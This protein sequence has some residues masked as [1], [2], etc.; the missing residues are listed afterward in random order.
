DQLDDDVLF[1]LGWATASEMG[2]I[3]G[4]GEVVIGHD[5]R[6]SSPGFARSFAAGVGAAGSRAVLLGLCS[7]DQLYFASGRSPRATTPPA[8][9]AQILSPLESAGLRLAGNIAPG[10]PKSPEAKESWPGEHRPN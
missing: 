1:A 4:S 2:E 9:G 3:H 5:M 8:P 7:T 6:P 10:R